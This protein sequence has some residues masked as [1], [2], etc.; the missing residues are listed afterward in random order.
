MWDRTK[1]YLIVFNGEIYNTTFLKKKL[2]GLSLDGSSDTEILINLYKIYG[3]K[4]LKMI[5]MLFHFFKQNEK[6]ERK[7]KS[8]C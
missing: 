2:R 1:R 8:T 6:N 4:I 5:Y 3:K 7:C